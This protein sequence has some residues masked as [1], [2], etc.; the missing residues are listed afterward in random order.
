MSA[1]RATPA[2]A[3]SLKGR[4]APPI[5][6]GLVRGRVTGWHVGRSFLEYIP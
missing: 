5:R 2:A 1:P 6:R 3:P 4:V